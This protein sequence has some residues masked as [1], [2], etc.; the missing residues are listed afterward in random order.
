MAGEPS[1]DPV[2]RAVAAAIV[3]AAIAW[4]AWRR[5]QFALGSPYPHGVDGYFYA[6]QLRSLLDSGQLRWPSPPLCFWLMW[7]LAALI[8]PVAALKA[9]AVA[10]TTA[11]AAPIYGIARELAAP[12]ALAIAAAILALT[13]PALFYFSTEFVKNGAGLTVAALAIWAALAADRRGTRRWWALFVLALLAAWLTHKSAAVLAVIATA[14][15]LWSASRRLSLVAIGAAVIAGLVA[16]ERFA[17]VA[18]LALAGDLFS[19]RIDLELPVQRL[20]GR[21]LLFG[22]E[23]LFAAL[24]A[25]AFIAAAVTRRI[26]RRPRSLFGLALLALVAAIPWID[27]ADP[28]GPGFRLRLLAFF[29]LALLVA[30]PGAALASRFGANTVAAAALGLAGFLIA[31]RPAIYRPPV[32]EQHPA[33][34]AAVRAAADH[35]PATGVVI[36]PERRLVFAYTYLTGGR[37][38]QHP[39]ADPRW[40]LVPLAY[41]TPALVT[42]IDQT[43]KQAPASVPRPISL[44][45]YSRDGLLLIPEPFWQDALS[46]LPTDQRSHYESWPTY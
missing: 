29:P 10:L 8:G 1:S 41:M 4:V 28:G 42:A 14:P 16:P 40:R 11:I 45:P 30:A 25:L 31:F 38:A 39:G 3:A 15:L 33:M 19:E 34:V 9:G 37:A 20:D 7:P 46:R 26:D 23:V 5:Y 17:G 21:T 43:R 18:D 24:A 2:P 32:V 36:T 35:V 27:V 44:H 13:S 12:R 6:A 22:R